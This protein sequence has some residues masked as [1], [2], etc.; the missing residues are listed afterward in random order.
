MKKM[1]ILVAVALLAA[2]AVFAQAADPNPNPNQAVLIDFTTLTGDTPV[3]TEGDPTFSNQNGATIMDFSGSRFAGSATDEQR[4]AMRTSLAIEQW[5]VMLTPSARTVTTAVRSFTRE[6]ASASR[7]TVMGARVHFPTGNFNATA[8]IRPPFEIPAF[9]QADQAA[10]GTVAAGPTRFEGGFGVVK[11]VATIR[12]IAVN[13]HGLNF[14]HTLFVVLL[15]Q[16][17][18]R[19]SV[20]MGNLQ[21]D[22]WQTL[23]WE[24][25]AYIQEVRNR[26]LRLRPI[27]PDSTPFVKFAGFEIHRDASNAG[28][29][30]IVYFQDVSMIYDQAVLDTERDID[31]EAIWGII[32]QREAERTGNEMERLAQHQILR[33][34]ERQKQAPRDLSFTTEQTAQ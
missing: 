32:Q 17:G 25:P 23:T 2:G 31:N 1:L 9:E 6:S 20:P 18:N 15:D 26:D 21:F 12:S 10:D 29:D 7:G 3:G 4:A 16:D 30:F 5:E 13:V 19:R 33:L 28:G 8:L 22:G 27:Y 14:P 11:N 24:N 34:Q